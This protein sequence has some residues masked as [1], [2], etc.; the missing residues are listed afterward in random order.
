MKHTNY[1]QCC[2]N[3]LYIRTVFYCEHLNIEQYIWNQSSI[4]Q[5]ELIIVI[6]YFVSDWVSQKIMHPT[7]IH[8]LSF[9]G[10][11]GHS[12]TLEYDITTL[13]VIY[14]ARQ[15]YFGLQI[16]MMMVMLIVNLMVMVVVMVVMRVMNG[17]QVHHDTYMSWWCHKTIW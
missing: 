15:M 1:S 7:K 16:S 11:Q 17:S 3:E 12:N 9:N 10:Q 14:H 8:Q 6:A 4:K 5:Q 2:I 13:P